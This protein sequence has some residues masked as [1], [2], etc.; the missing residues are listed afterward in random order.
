MAKA[1]NVIMTEINDAFIEKW[2]SSKRE[3][4]RVTIMEEALNFAEKRAFED[5]GIG[6]SSLSMEVSKL[7]LIAKDCLEKQE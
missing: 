2:K 7:I 4:K 1:L 3:Q 6:Q 5:F